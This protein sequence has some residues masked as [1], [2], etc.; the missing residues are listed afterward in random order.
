MLVACVWLLAGG[1]ATAAESKI[2]S[3]PLTARVQHDPFVLEFTDRRSG[4]TLRTVGAEAPD[5][6]LARYGPPGYS[7]DLR[8]PVIGNAYLGYYVAAEVPTVWFH[9]RR[10]L[11]VRREGR[12]LVLEAAT[13]DP[14]GHRLEVTLTKR[15]LGI[16]T[17]ASRILPGSGLVP[18]LEGLAS[19]SGA[20]FATRPGERFLG[21]GERSNAAD[22]TGNEVFNWAEEGPFSSGEAE[23]IMR[24]LIPDF[25]FPTGPTATNF[26]IP[27]MLSSRGLGFL[28]DQDERS[29]FRLASERGD[30]WQAE[31][32]TS[33]FRFSVFAGPS[34]AAALRRY[35]AYAGRQPRPANWVFGPWFQPTLEAAPYELADRFRAE[36]V[37]VTVAQT[38]THYL[39]CGAH[40]GNPQTERVNGYHR[41]GYKITT[42]FNPHICTSYDA[43]YDAAAAQ[44]LLVENALGQPYLL[45]NPFTAD[46]IVSEV[47]FTHPDGPA[48][49]GDL[50][51]DA[52][53]DGYDGWM[54]DFG[55]YTPTDSRFANGKG[56]LKMHNAYPVEYHCASYRHTRETMGRD[57]A[58]FIRSGWHGVQPCARVVWGGDPTEDWS[59]SDG[60]CAA[61]HQALSIG[62]SGIAYWGSDIGGFHAI[63]NPRTDDE[64]NARWLEFGAVSG[65]MRTQ[66]NGFSFEDDR[67][68]RSQVWHPAVLPIWRRYAK[69]RTQLLPYLRAASRTYQRTRDADR[70]APGARVSARR[71]GRGPA[72]RVHVRPRPPRRARGRGGRARAA[73]LRAA[74]RL[75]RPL[76]LGRVRGAPGRAPPRA[77]QADPRRA[78]DHRPRAA[79]RAAVARAGGRDP[80]AAAARHRHPRRRGA[81][82]GSREA[83]RAPLAPGALRVP[84]RAVARRPRRRP[85]RLAGGQA[86]VGAAAAR[87]RAPLQAAGVARDAPPPPSPLRGDA[88]GRVAAAPG[89]ELRRRAPGTARAVPGARRHARRASLR[90]GRIAS[91]GMRRLFPEPAVDVSVE[92][93]LADLRPGDEAPGDRPRVFSN[94]VLTLDGRATIGGV[95]GPIGSD[96]DTEM[97]V[98][99]RTR[100]DAVMI[101]AGT[102]RAERYGRVPN[103]RLLVIVS[104]RLDLPWDAK[105]FTCGAGEV[106]VFTSADTEPPETATPV[107]VVRHENAVDLGAALAHLR[108]EHDVASLLCEG[109]PRL[110]AQLLDSGLVDELFVTRAPKLAG[111]E[112]PGLVEGLSHEERALELAW[113]VLEPETGEL[114]ARYVVA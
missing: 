61:V 4:E 9:A 39:P 100:A 27:W 98:G 95:S 41:R 34:P 99:L 28:I 90:R 105:L 70:P 31:A 109:G 22:Q 54:E 14:L 85:G 84:A 113:L 55:E 7:F 52:T 75:D 2:R 8:I 21:F 87:T 108:S 30:A 57:A 91:P 23:E 37:P 50:L 6:A 17:A 110:H 46:Q 33:R 42:Y 56:G 51:D 20:A 47:D 12:A 40:V 65:V 111:G 112:G 29:R 62:M 18:G 43:V 44:G 63:V 36:D 102:M 67:A 38:Y 74:R 103:D 35:S 10:V 71:A 3:G 72:G 86:R 79:R 11:A 106:L 25:T 69:L 92:E 83:A 24:P 19:V 82:A 15:R 5:A 107:Q 94:F 26:P 78:R 76:A 16:I 104:G 13:N 93:L 66:A 97:L 64:L 80:P 88:R 59:C 68:D 45:T 96:H 32:E 58:V 114:F 77:R 101:G 89:M 81:R 1:T 48:F 49:F 53:A 60:L 73:P